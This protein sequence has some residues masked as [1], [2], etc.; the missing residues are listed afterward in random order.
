MPS[1]RKSKKRCI[2]NT[3]MM[4]TL[5][6]SKIRSWFQPWNNWAFVYDH[7]WIDSGSVYC[8]CRSVSLSM[9]NHLLR[10]IRWIGTRT[11]CFTFVDVTL[12]H[13]TWYNSLIPSKILLTTFYIK[14]SRQQ[15]IPP[16]IENLNSICVTV[17]K[18]D[19]LTKETRYS[20]Q[21]LVSP[22]H[23]I[24]CRSFKM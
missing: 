5:C 16:F 15:I 21:G 6:N 20:K 9:D 13:K 10:K 3:T 1:T 14:E 18:N 23:S 2:H 24:P 19:S 17:S 8:G 4:S 11:F 12:K 22:H 7:N